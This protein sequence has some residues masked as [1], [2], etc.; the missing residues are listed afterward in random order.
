MAQP[1][2]YSEQ[3][4]KIYPPAVQRSG[5]LRSDFH[6]IT[7]EE[8]TRDQITNDVHRDRAAFGS[9]HM[10][11]SRT[12]SRLNRTTFLWIADWLA[13]LVA[14]SLPWSTSATQI[15][16]VAW[17]FSLLPALVPAMIRRELASAA[18]GL[19]VLLW[20]LALI[21]TMWSDVSWSDRLQ[22]LDSFHRL[23]VIP[24]LLAQ[25]RQ[26][27]NGHRVLFGFVISSVLLLI[28]SFILVLIPYLPWHGKVWGIPVHDDVLQGSIFLI[29]AFA[30]LGVARA[31]FSQRR[32]RAAVTSSAIAGLFLLNFAFVQ[33]SRTAVPV[34]LVLFCLLGWR[35]YRWRGIVFGLI[36]AIVLGGAFWFASSTVRE[37][38]VSSMREITNYRATNESTP[39]GQHIAY[40]KEGLAI[41]ASAPIIGH[42][43]GSMSAQFRKVTSG[44]SGVSGEATDNPHNQTFTVAIQLGF[45]GAT[46]LWFMWIAHLLLFRG[47]GI[48]AWI[49]T[50]VV[51][52]NVVSSVFHS[53]LFDF[54][55]GWLY[56]FGV[57]VLG[58][59]ILREH[60]AG[61]GQQKREV[62]TLTSDSVGQLS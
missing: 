38:A 11:I 12:T 47:E 15:F 22:G 39:L 46:L 49:G 41:I 30:L 61:Q 48:I 53:H 29:C 57:G 17:L 20:C 6:A 44:K 13:V 2:R 27:E 34:V 14:V 60:D 5:S 36:G 40:L 35:I 32:W 8:T 28:T 18:G 54:G 59:M 43:T 52:E 37:R 56:I 21:G 7:G 3:A 9:S 33:I 62:I 25:F 58:G 31:A 42:G 23:L 26:S 1:A 4:R 50:V 55:N 16:G 45:V 10:K 51:V 24:A 19:P